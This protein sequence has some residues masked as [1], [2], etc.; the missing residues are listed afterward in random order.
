MRNV[1]RAKWVA[2]FDMEDLISLILRSGMVMTIGFVLA[3]L[4]LRWAGMGG[5][6]VD[7]TLQGTNVLQFMLADFRLAGSPRFWP[8]GLTHLGVAALLLTPAI[9]VGASL[10]YFACVQ[11]RWEHALLNGLVLAT[12]TYILF[13]G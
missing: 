3:G 4:A 7:E 5:G 13:F 8:Q 11:R 9:R 2:S 1:A 12:L 6:E 10:C